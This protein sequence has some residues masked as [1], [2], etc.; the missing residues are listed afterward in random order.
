[1]SDDKIAEL[2]K[3]QNDILK[4]FYQPQIEHLEAENKKLRLMLL[5]KVSKSNKSYAR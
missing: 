4:D 3:I 2:L 5:K 1:M